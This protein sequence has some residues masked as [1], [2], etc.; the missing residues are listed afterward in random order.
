MWPRW[1]GPT[2][3]GPKP[4]NSPVC[5]LSTYDRC[6]KA[7][8]AHCEMCNWVSI[9]YVTR[10]GM[11]NQSSYV[12]LYWGDYTSNFMQRI[13]SRLI[14]ICLTWFV[15]ELW[16][17]QMQPAMVHVE[18]MVN[19]LPFGTWRSRC[20][21]QY[22]AKGH[23]RAFAWL[24]NLLYAWLIRLVI[25]SVNFWVSRSIGPPLVPR[26]TQFLS[27]YSERPRMCAKI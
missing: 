13:T 11:L 3:N 26:T 25:V 17:R 12:C 15:I 22:I 16:I 8:V 1:C 2:L 27:T 23:A 20:E 9:S 4:I 5:F 10:K 18:S 21:K 19:I 7:L 14:T 24:A 6:V